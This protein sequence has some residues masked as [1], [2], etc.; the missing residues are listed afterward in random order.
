MY[1]S[2]IA[3]TLLPIVMSASRVQRSKEWAFT[4]LPLTVGGYNL[5]MTR[6]DVITFDC[7]GTLINWEDGIWTA[8]ENVGRQ[9]GWQLSRDGVLS[10][11]SEVEPVV[12]GEIFRSYHE[13]LTESSKR[14]LRT[15]GLDLPAASEHFLAESLPRWRPFEDTNR[16]LERLHAAGYRLGILSNV[17]DDLLART[18]EHLPVS[19]DPIITAEQVR[20]YKPELGHFLAARSILGDARWLHAAQSYFHDVVPARALQIPVAWINRHDSVPELEVRPDFELRSLDALADLLA[21][22]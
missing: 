3:H 15:F 5:P 1:P 19:F 13:T 9:C 22:T 12:E 7:Y 17:D 11:Y 16:A 4:T 6:F 10:A 18:L 2:A 14:V 8:F 21:A 20:S